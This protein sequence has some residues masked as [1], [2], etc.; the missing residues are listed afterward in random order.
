MTFEGRK[1]LIVSR[2]STQNAGNEALSKILIDFV[3]QRATGSQVFALDRYPRFFE[4][5]AI[6]PK[7]EKVVE[8]FDVQARRLIERFASSDADAPPLANRSLVKLD[9]SAKELRGFWRL[10]KRR[11]GLRRRLASL[12]LIERRDPVT[13]VSACAR[14]DL[15]IWNGAGEI[16]P[17]GDVN[18]VFRLLLLLRISQLSGKRTA[19]V[20]HSLEVKDVRL[21]ALLAHVYAKFDYVGVRDATSAEVAR[22][23]GVDPARIFEAPDLVFM[24]SR[25]ITKKRS[26]DVPKGAIGLAINGLEALSGTDEWPELMAGLEALGRPIIFV[27]N[28][29]NHDIDFSRALAQMASRA[30][31]VSH[32]PGYE[33]LRDHFRQCSVVVSSRL[34]SSI[35]SL[36]EGVPVVSIEPSMFKLTAIFE[37]LNYPIRTESLTVAGWAGRILQSVARCLSVPDNQLGALGQKSA[38][39]QAARIELAYRP[40][41][42]LT[43]SQPSR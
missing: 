35:L 27:S 33:A 16:H 6:D 29:V 19:V 2:L 9:H 14:C 3:A 42:D 5:L 43:N 25:E 15:V 22:S 13:A 41:L 28:A 23:L 39:K 34:H 11:V 4:K 30:Q 32:Q 10:V 26:A 40:L 7:T 21:R 31:V 1:I 37:Q 36:S 20:N 17:T 38:L 18:Q 8:R 12:G 24:A